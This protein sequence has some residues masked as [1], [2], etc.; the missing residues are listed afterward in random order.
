MIEVVQLNQNPVALWERFSL[1]LSPGKERRHFADLRIDHRAMGG[2]WSASFSYYD[3]PVTLRQF[4]ADGLGRD[5]RMTN[6]RGVIAFEGFISSMRLLG[7]SP[8]VMSRSIDKI[9]NKVWVRYKDSGGTFTRSANG[10]GLDS[11]ARYGIKELPLSGGQLQSSS[12]ANNISEMVV[13]RR[14]WS[15][16]VVEQM[17][18]GGSE[19]NVRPR[20]DVSCQGYIHTL[21]WRVYN[22]TASTGTQAANLEI[23]DVLAAAG[24]YVKAWDLQPN[25]VAVTKE[26]DADKWAMDILFDIAKLGDNLDPPQRW[27]LYMD[28]GRVVRYEP[29]APP[30]YVSIG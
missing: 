10:T 5:V 18:L 19:V 25:T 23:A 26:Y 16:V 24:Q 13:Q 1:D 20:L 12:I 4:F 3:D 11:Q 27:T 6:H 15:K 29:A 7:L 30:S 28:V 8:G 9:A 2:F 17:Q 21:R 14:Q 22:Q